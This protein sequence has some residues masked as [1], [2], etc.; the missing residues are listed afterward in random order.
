[1]KKQFGP[2]NFRLIF[3]RVGLCFFLVD[4]EGPFMPHGRVWQHHN[5]WTQLWFKHCNIYYVTRKWTI[6]L[7]WWQWPEDALQKDPGFSLMSVYVL[8][9]LYVIICIKE[10]TFFLAF[11]WH[12]WDIMEKRFKLCILRWWQYIPGCA[13]LLANVIRISSSIQEITRDNMLDTYW[14]FIL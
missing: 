4:G 10:K 5:S 6:D 3:H 13:K 9:V 1:M 7:Q 8:H 14:A 2:W 12:F 11:I